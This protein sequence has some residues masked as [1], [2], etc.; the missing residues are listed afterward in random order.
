MSQYP[1]LKEMGILNPKQIEKFAVYSTDDQDILR[2]IY[3]R[4]K[5]SPLPVSKKF[6]FPRVKKTVISDSGTRQTSMVY[7]SVSAFRDALHEL[8]QLKLER[9]KSDDLAAQINEE[10]RFLEEDVALR[11]EYIRSLVKKI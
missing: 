4:K 7:E 2:V 6:K 11:I 10:I 8:E 9:N 5:G 3:K 1:H